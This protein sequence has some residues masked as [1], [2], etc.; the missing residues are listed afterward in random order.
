LTGSRFSLLDGKRQW[1]GSLQRL[2][3]SLH[4]VTFQ[5]HIHPGAAQHGRRGLMLNV[6]EAVEQER[7]EIRTGWKQL[8]AQPAEF[9]R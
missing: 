7:F 9:V 5:E 8:K 6:R 1:E 2:P 3:H 4:T